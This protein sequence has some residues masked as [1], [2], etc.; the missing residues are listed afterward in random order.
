MIKNINKI[1]LAILIAIG[2]QY[3]M[4]G[5]FTFNTIDFSSFSLLNWLLEIIYLTFAV[6]FSLRGD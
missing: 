1:S 6:S 5:A 3:F 4:V 2:M